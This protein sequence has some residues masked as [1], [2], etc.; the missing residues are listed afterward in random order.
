MKALFSTLPF[1]FLLCILFTGNHTFAAQEAPQDS[2][3]QAITTG[4]KLFHGQKR[5][6]NRG[7]ACI[8][9]HHVSDPQSSI[10]GGTYGLELTK[11]YET[12][13]AEALHTF[14]GN[15]PFP[16]MKAA[17]EDRPVTEEEIQQLTAYLQYTSDT[18]ATRASTAAA[19]LQFLWI[20]LG[21]FLLI[22]LA[23][24]LAWRKRKVGSVNKQ[25]YR[26]QLQSI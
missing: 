5:L 22:L 25:I 19:G 14:I 1:L 15:S 20:G 24:W 23:I 26:R 17:F 8:S 6:T 21:G 2:L 4:R 18:G 16:V 9:C 11:M 13:G 3:Q 10:S 7:P 12:F